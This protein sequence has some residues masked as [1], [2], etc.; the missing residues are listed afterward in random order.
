MTNP[1]LE[2]FESL[3]YVILKG[4]YPESVVEGARRAAWQSD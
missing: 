2:H 3:G 4:F 1:E